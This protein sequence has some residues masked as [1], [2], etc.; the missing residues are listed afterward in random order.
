V[1]KRDRKMSFK[2]MKTLVGEEIK[3]IS[4]RKETAVIMIMEI[5]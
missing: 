1:D 3:L 4:L 5:L 2:A